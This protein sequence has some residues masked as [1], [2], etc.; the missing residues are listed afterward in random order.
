[1]FPL[2]FSIEE[3]DGPRIFVTVR[4]KF[5]QTDKKKN[6]QLLIFKTKR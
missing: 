6:F 5:F 3:F 4:N 1:M 2:R